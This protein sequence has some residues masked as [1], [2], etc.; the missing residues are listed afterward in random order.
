MH[1]TKNKD[2]LKSLINIKQINFYFKTILK[3]IRFYMFTFKRPKIS[4]KR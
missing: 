3:F 2:N 4:R 1:T